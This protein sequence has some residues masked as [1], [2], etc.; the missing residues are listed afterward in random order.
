MASAKKKKPARRIVADWLGVSSVDV[1]QD[2]RI[3]AGENGGYRVACFDASGA[4]AWD[5]SLARAGSS[6]RYQFET[7]VAL[8]PNGEHVLALM[9]DSATIVVL[10]L[11]SGARVGEHSIP[12]TRAFA[13][14]ADGK[15]IIL[16]VSTETQ[17]LAF[18]SFEPLAAFDAYCN[19]NEIAVSPDGTWFAVA[20]HEVHVFDAKKLVHRKTFEPPESPW[21]MCAT[22]SGRQLLTGDAKNMLRVYDAENDF[23]KLVEVGK[24]RSPTITAIAASADGKWIATVNELGTVY[25]HDAGTLA[26]VHELKGHDASQPD[27]GS[28]SISSLAFF[29]NEL[30][31][32]A[33]PKKEPQGLTVHALAP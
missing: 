14:G 29:R 26:I 7:Q 6:S 8:A 21:A 20:G 15:K 31:V 5:V 13:L 16:R 23:V 28:K 27:T 19:Q 10:D 17:V 25:V 9:K 12:Q 32:G 11:A 2:G 1:A 33:P 18:P 30:V 4:L 22:A 3:V 24:N